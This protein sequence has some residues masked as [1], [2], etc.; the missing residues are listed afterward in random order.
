MAKDPDDTETL[1]LFP[2]EDDPPCQ[3]LMCAI[4]RREAAI[5]ETLT[6]AGL[7]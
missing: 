5:Q 3:C 6:E 1:E 4:R 7:D 2:S